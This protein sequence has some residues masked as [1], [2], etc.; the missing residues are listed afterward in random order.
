MKQKVSPAV[1]VV[2]IAAAIALASVVGYKLTSK[3]SSG[4]RPANYEEMT[5]LHAGAMSGKMQN[6]PPA[7]TSDKP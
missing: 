1:F 4:P 7:K 2:V 5:R 3:P 6:R